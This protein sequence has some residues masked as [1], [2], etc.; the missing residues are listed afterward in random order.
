ML[1]KNDYLQ[2]IEIIENAIAKS[3][4]LFES[5]IEFGLM[6][7]QI[8]DILAKID[9]AYALGSL[10]KSD[11]DA[12][13]NLYSKLESDLQKDETDYHSNKELSEIVQSINELYK[14]TKN[15]KDKKAT[16]ELGRIL[17]RLKG[18]L[19]GSYN[20]FIDKYLPF[21]QRTARTYTKLFFDMGGEYSQ[22]NNNEYEIEEITKKIN[23]L[24]SY[25]KN[26]PD[27]KFAFEIGSL[28]VR[29][30]D[31]LPGSYNEFVDTYLPF[32]QRS[33]RTYARTFFDMGGTYTP[34]SS[35]EIKEDIKSFLKK[36]EQIEDE[37]NDTDALISILKPQ[38][39]DLN[40]DYDERSKWW[41]DRDEEGKIV[42]YNYHIYIRDSLPLSGYFTCEQMEEIYAKYPYVT[43]NTIS[44]DF[45][46]ITFPDFKKILRCFNITKDKLFP[47]HIIETRSEDELA[48]FALKAK[49]S[50]GYK[51]MIEKKSEYFEKRFKDVQ[52][53]LLEVQTDR[54]WIEGVLDKYFDENR[55]RSVETIR[56]SDIQKESNGNEARHP[57]LF[58]FMS[59]LHIGKFYKNPIYGRGYD[60]D[61]AKERFEQMAFHICR[62]AHKYDHL[63][64]LCGG[65]ITE[66]IMEDGLHHGIHKH[67]D[68]FQDD[69]IMY[70]LDLFHSLFSTI[71]ENTNF[72]TIELLG[73]EG[74]H[75]RIGS[76]RHDDK[77]RTAAKV[78]YR[79]LQREW[80]DKVDVILAE[81]GIIN[82]KREN[83][84]IISHHGDA[85]LAKRKGDELVNLFGDGKRFY[86]LVIKGHFHHLECKEGTN[87]INIT[88]PSVCSADTY[89]ITEFA[90]NSQPGFIL[91][92]QAEFGLGFDFKKITLL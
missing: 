27:K 74:N 82:Q 86:H 20:D 60:K 53:N 28:L 30:K 92:H 32:T 16:F 59:D 83:I 7:N 8:L 6:P 66:S 26:D 67:M 80:K 78:V 18:I 9:A 41:V 33:A 45:P 38:K 90:Q 17:V 77:N 64:I 48:A 24:S 70:A 72:K 89:S 61:I 68:L 57:R 71:F 58:C 56:F 23:Q 79:F 46:Y 34:D 63:T 87:F 62:E 88:L 54:Q 65:D 10:S 81:E 37:Y 52:K 39:I 84:C 1:T 44:R 85:N 55:N 4:N 50:A 11:W 29:L 5:A 76:Q 42:K 51:K 12:Y 3:I 35:F 25:T 49:E 14:H 2:A 15:D 69:Q 75:D 31:L 22:E 19:F 43:Q 47:L 91:G 21:N 73:L 40:D 36:E 13:T